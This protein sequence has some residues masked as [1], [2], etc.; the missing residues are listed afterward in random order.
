MGTYH[1]S[2][3]SLSDAADRANLGTN[4]QHA[5]QKY[6]V[7]GAILPARSTRLREKRCLT[8]NYRNLGLGKYL[9]VNFSS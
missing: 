8:A 7:K 3:W 6:A 1:L 5:L 4:L 9:H 2:T